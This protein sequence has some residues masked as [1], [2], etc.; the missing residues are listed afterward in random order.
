MRSK[1]TYFMEKNNNYNNK[2]NNNGTRRWC[3]KNPIPNIVSKNK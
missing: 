2:S 3:K 1:M